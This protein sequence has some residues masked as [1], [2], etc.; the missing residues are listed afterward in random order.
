MHNFINQ[1]ALEMGE[2][3]KILT[4]Y[5]PFAQ[6]RM[7][8]DRPVSIY[9]VDDEEN[10]QNVLG[11]TAFYSPESDSIVVYVTGRHPKRS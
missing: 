8:F 5:V 3:E 6:Q 9:A 7:G 2:V 1:S 11:M 4:S 10:S